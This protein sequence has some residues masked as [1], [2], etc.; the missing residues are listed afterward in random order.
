MH[1][2]CFKLVGIEYKTFGGTL[3]ESFFEGCL[4]QSGYNQYMA[5]NLPGI[6][7]K[8]G[9]EPVIDYKSWYCPIAYFYS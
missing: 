8:I 7:H 1:R 3:C 9:T 6:L 5:T 2:A 4:N